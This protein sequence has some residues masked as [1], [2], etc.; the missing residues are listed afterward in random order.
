MGAMALGVGAALFWSL[1]FRWPGAVSLSCLPLVASVALYLCLGM[2]MLSGSPHRAYMSADL[3]SLPLEGLAMRLETHLRTHPQDGEGWRL[4]APVLRELGRTE[5]AAEAY[6]QALRFL[7]T[8]HDLLMGYGETLVDLKDGV[9]S[10]PARQLFQDIL[11]ADPHHLRAAYFLALAAYQ[12]GDQDAALEQIAA[13]HARAPTGSPLARF[14]AQ[15][16]HRLG[17]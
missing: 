1:P 16:L 4:L 11:T 7:G 14:L 6:E 2:P 9:V 13:L 5:A 8:Q 3:E 10:E 12:D 15:E 17:G